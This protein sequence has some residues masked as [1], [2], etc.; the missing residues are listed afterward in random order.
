LITG[1]SARAVGRLAAFP[2]STIITISA[3]IGAAAEAAGA[4]SLLESLP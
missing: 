4:A 3:S 1:R 2:M